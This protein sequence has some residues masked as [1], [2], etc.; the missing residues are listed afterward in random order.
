ML[1]SHEHMTVLY[2]GWYLLIKDKTVALRPKGNSDT[3]SQNLVLSV[4]VLPYAN[5][6]RSFILTELREM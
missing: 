1:S 4:F 5:L 6:R 3:G 2:F